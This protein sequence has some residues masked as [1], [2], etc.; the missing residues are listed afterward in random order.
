LIFDFGLR[1][2][3]FEPVSGEIFLAVEGDL[4]KRDAPEVIPNPGVRHEVAEV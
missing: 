3:L 2:C 4:P 1:G